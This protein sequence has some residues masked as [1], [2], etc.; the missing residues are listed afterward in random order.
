M[1]SDLPE[2]VLDAPCHIRQNAIFDAHQAYLASP[3]C[4]FRSCQAPRQTIKFNNSNYKSGKWYPNLTKKMGCIS[5][6]PLPSTT[7]FA[8]QLIKTK[9]GWFAVFL[10]ERESKPTSGKER[11]IALDPGVRTFLTGFDG[12]RFMEIGQGDMSR[13]AR[14]C[15]HLDSLMSRI[16]RSSS[17]RQ[18]QRMRKAAARMRDKIRNLVDEMTSIG[19]LSRMKEGRVGERGSGGVGE[20]GSGRINIFPL[21]SSLFP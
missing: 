21:P 5:S 17:S 8:T 13:I 3:Y 2:W 4:K 19:F 16:A 20:W 14:L 6:E 15:Q 7:K 12:N 11:I 18:R 1:N 9:V 10:E